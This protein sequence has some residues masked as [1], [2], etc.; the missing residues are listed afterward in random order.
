M[1]TPTSMSPAQAA[2]TLGVSRM[3]II[4]AIKA[5][6][7][8]AFRDN[9]NNWQIAPENLQA[10]ANVHAQ[11]SEQKPTVISHVQGEVD[12]LKERLSAVTARA[13][14]AEADR[15]AWRSMAEKLAENRRRWRWPWR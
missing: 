2:Q 1:G 7:L 12:V 4:R 6:E 3:T 14:A 8:T 11:I 13:E 15:D 5:N 10:W 9:R